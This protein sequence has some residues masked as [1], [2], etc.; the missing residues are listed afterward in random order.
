MAKQTARQSRLVGALYAR[1]KSVE[2]AEL[3]GRP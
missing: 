3:S 1:T 2:H